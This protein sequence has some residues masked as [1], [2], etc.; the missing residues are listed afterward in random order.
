[1]LDELT[2][3]ATELWCLGIPVSVAQQIDAGR[4]L[5][6]IDPLDAA[7]VYAAL[8]TTLTK[9]E[10]IQLVTDARYWKMVHRRAAASAQVAQRR[11]Q[12]ELDRARVREAGLRAELELARAQLRDLRQRVFGAKTEQSRLI[13]PSF[14][15][16]ATPPRP[17]GQQRGG[18]GHGRQRLRHLPTSVQTLELDTVCPQCG[19]GLREFPG[20]E[21][22]EVLE[23]EVQAYRRV[24][25]R[26]RCRP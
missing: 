4:A 24:I 14:Q 9:R 5:T 12:R 11:H 8:S 25:R 13:N 19:M 26:P 23:I 20:A 21:E 10:H 7:E 17:R 2:A 18:L 3:I 16:S 15:T 6:A 1:M 22:C